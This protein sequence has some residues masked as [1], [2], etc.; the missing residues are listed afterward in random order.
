MEV[1]MLPGTIINEKQRQIYYEN[2]LWSTSTVFDYFC[3]TVNK[4]PRKIAIV[5]RGQKISYKMLFERVKQ[6]ANGLKNLQIKKGDF[7]SV[8][9]PNW[10]E[11]VIIYLACTK[12]GAIYNPIPYTARHQ[13]VKYILSL[14]ESKVFVIPEQFRNFNY[15]EMVNLIQDDIG[16]PR[17]I[18]VNG[19]EDNSFLLFEDVLSMESNDFDEDQVNADDPVVVLFTSGTESVPKGVIHTHNTV[20]Y[21]E[22]LLSESLSITQDDAVF[23]ASPLSHSTGF[24]RGVNLPMMIGAKSVLMDH[25]SPG[26]AL[27][28]ICEEKC[29]FSMG[30]TP[31]LYDLL[32]E[33]SKNNNE[34]DLSSF[35]F[36]LCGGAPIP[37]HMVTEANNCG[38]KVLAVYGSSESSPHA[39]SRLDDSEELVVSS[40]GKPLPGIE[41]KI[42]DENRNEL[43]QGEIGEEASRGPNVFLGYFKQPELTKKYLDE[44]G[45]YYS[46]DLGVLQPNHYLRIVGRKKDIIIRGGQNISPAEVEN[47]LYKHSKIEK[48]SIIGVPDERMGE[49]A[50]AIV[51]PKEG[52]I[53]TFEEMID[54]LSEQKIAKYKYPE[55]LYLTKE[56][57]TTPSGKIQKRKI[58]EMLKGGNF[59]KGKIPF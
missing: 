18:I 24:L 55:K 22:R 38:F 19:T 14:C 29:T 48:V 33:I 42:V 20:L 28:I 15:I 6:V 25:F 43:P 39:V 46:G 16:I 17:I 32:G 57:P 51:V 50:C 58:L 10:A 31:F 21:G 30:S 27:Q 40:D 47:L 4:F 53:F 34:Y 11:N 7:V 23:M 41:V 5:D 35:R 9:L 8:Q 12:I 26:K 3:E 49:R 54:F 2:G 52:Q 37:R 36:F 59:D 13:E 45:W 56:L 44:D 1:N